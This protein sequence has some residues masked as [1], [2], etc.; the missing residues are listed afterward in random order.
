MTRTLRRRA[1]RSAPPNPA[2]RTP[3]LG[4]GGAG[5]ARRSTYARRDRLAGRSGPR[6]PRG[7]RRRP[8]TGARGRG[9]RAR[10]PPPGRDPGASRRKLNG[11]GLG[12]SGP[13]ESRPVQDVDA[14]SW[15][16]SKAALPAWSLPK[17]AVDRIALPADWPERVTR[18]W[19][20]GGSTGE[21]VRVCILDSGVDASHPLVGELESAVVISVGEDDEI[22]AERGH[23][24][25]RLRPRHRVRRD[26]APARPRRADLE[27]PRSRLELHGLGSGAPRRPALR[28]RAGVR[29]H[30]HEPLHDEE[31]VR[32]RPP[33]ARR[34]RVLQ[35]HRARRVGAQHA[36]RE[37]PVALLVGDLG[38][39]PRGARSAR[40]LLQPEP[41]RRVLRTRGERRGA[42]ARRARPHRLGQQLRDPAH[43]LDLRARS[44]R[45]TPS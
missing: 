42:V 6:V 45:S 1:S 4:G 22:V 11:K 23:G 39:E 17:D 20:L 8:R 12:G 13:V 36:R 16:A 35:P 14:H 31:A 41:A 38:R 9:L 33:R 34:Q 37:L 24:G 40:L 25:R 15:D 29:R 21:G 27:R 32:E 43:D 18:E 26:R 5:A 7:T 28:D 10:P 19:A 3:R 2:S 44:S 30:Q